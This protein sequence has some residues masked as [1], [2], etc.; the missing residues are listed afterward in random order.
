MFASDGQHI[1]A[2]VLMAADFNE[3]LE[4]LPMHT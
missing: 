2:Q 1:F 4:T 3:C